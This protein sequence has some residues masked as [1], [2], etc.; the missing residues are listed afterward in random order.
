MDELEEGLC[1]HVCGKT[2]ECPEGEPLCHVFKGWFTVTCW[3]GL[4]EVSQY[5]FCSLD[6]LKSWV[7]GET[8]GIPEV[9]L[10]SFGED[11]S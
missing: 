11:K 5:S 1:C 7:E 8:H 3:D 2:L 4:G 6:C 10:E 9:F